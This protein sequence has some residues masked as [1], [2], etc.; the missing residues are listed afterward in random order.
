MRILKFFAAF[1]VTAVLIFA[2][3]FGLN[4]KSFT[5]FME[6]REAMA[7]GSEWVEKTYSLRGL[8]EFIAENP[9]NISIASMVVQ[10]PDSVILY[11]P[12]VRRVMGTTS[13][14][15]LLLAWAEV[16]ASGE[17]S[18]ETMLP[19]DD[20]SRFQL[21]DVEASVLQNS[22]RTARNRGWIT[23][24]SISLSH[25]LKLL[26]QY[27]NLALADYL[28]WKLGPDYWTEFNERLNLTQTDAPLPFSGLYL[29]IAPGIMEMSGDDIVNHWQDESDEEWRNHVMELSIGFTEE[30][31]TRQ[32]ISSYLK[33]NRLGGSFIEERNAMILF[34][35]TT[36]REMAELM[37]NVWQAENISE[38]AS[39]LMKDWMRWP[40]E[41]QRE[42]RRDFS[43]YGAIFDNRL[44][45][46]NGV[47]FG[48]STYTGDTTVQAVFFDRLPIAF[49]FHMSSNHMHQDFQQRLIFD[50]AMIDRMKEIVR[51][52]EHSAVTENL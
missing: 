2:F 29:A 37:R 48:T 24:E 38:E 21:P 22:F 17:E 8:S 23:D 51:R 5:T 1:F 11:Q 12:D 43:D 9:Q 13:N 20:I 39:M 19:W 44:G 49:W 47:D 28:W 50:P 6:N 45:L 7:E 36:A 34:P 4:W 40:L 35:K 10:H 16:I 15:L 52:H 26:A 27:N 31:E 46:L 42:V 41:Q 14:Y 30:P 33:R 3:V 25:A 32:Q 18:P